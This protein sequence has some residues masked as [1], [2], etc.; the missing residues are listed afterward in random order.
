MLSRLYEGYRF[1]PPHVVDNFL[2]R[3]PPLP[4]PPLQRAHADPLFG[5]DLLNGDASIWKMLLHEPADSRRSFHWPR[6]VQSAIRSF[7]RSIDNTEVDDDRV[8][9]ASE[10]DRR[11]MGLF[12]LID[13]PAIGQREPHADRFRHSRQ[14]SNFPQHSQSEDVLH[15]VEAQF[16]A[17]GKFELS[18]AVE[19]DET[20][21]AALVQ[22]LDAM[23]RD[24]ASLSERRRIRHHTAPST[25]FREAKTIPDARTGKFLARDQAELMTERETMFAQDPASK[26]LGRRD[27]GAPK[28][29]ERM[30]AAIA[31]IFRDVKQ[32]RGIM[33]VA[34]TQ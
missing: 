32:G 10:F 1:G 27:V 28:D 3:E 24:R 23:G 12:K 6:R 34:V 17:I 30:D 26:Q 21:I 7:Q 2:K 14:Q 4:Q 20:K 19:L 13:A 15:G 16:A 11:T 25:K 31:Q 5:G 9:S 22:K 29:V 18:V 8:V 33:S